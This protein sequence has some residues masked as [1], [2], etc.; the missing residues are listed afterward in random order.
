ME[1]S[2][3]FSG[4]GCRTHW[5]SSGRS[6]LQMCSLQ[7]SNISK[8]VFL[9]SLMF[10]FFY[11]LSLQFFVTTTQ[12]ALT[13]HYSIYPRLGLPLTH[14]SPSQDRASRQTWVELYIIKKN[15]FMSWCDLFKWDLEPVTEILFSCT[16]PSERRI[17][18]R[19]RR[20]W[21]SEV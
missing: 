4:N 15:A 2:S 7:S 18:D 16:V 13:A 1:G 21:S 19:N 6:I 14:L 5:L 3:W 8:T 10:F 20:N 11:I 17:L 12:A 9:F